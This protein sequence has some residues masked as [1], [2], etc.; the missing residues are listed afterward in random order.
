MF[1]EI[2]RN[3]RINYEYITLDTYTAGIQLKGSEVKSLKKGN[4]NLKDSFCII[5]NGEIY[6]KNMYISEYNHGGT[7]NNH[8]PLR[9]RKILLN[10]K[11]IQYLF[12]KVKERGL[13]IIPKSVF[14]NE[15]GLIKV[16]I[17][18]CKGKKTYDKAKT[19]KLRD[20][21]REIKNNI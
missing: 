3:K 9:D 16:D 6:I 12:K 7:H 14:I 5:I 20:L 13:S 11:E 18:L 21:D 17:S 15:N 10:K 1:K 2:I 4:V 8:E 19:I